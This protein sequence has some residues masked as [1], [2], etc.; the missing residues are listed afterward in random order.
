M[1]SGDGA[2]RCGRPAICKIRRIR[3]HGL[4]DLNFKNHKTYDLSSLLVPPHLG[5]QHHHG[6]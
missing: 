2:Y 5:M 4:P 3:P 6:R 1:V